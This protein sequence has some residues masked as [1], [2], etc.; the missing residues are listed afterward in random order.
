ME[1][2]YTGCR[3]KEHMF[4][5]V[6]CGA[7]YHIGTVHFCPTGVAYFPLNKTKPISEEKL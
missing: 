2:C 5:C 4:R 7:E 1:D 6:N 3:K